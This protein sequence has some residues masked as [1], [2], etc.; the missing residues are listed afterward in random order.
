MLPVL[1]NTIWAFAFFYFL[2]FLTKSAA[3]TYGQIS[4]CNISFLG[5]KK[6]TW[7][8][9]PTKDQILVIILK[10]K[11]YTAL[12]SIFSKTAQDRDSMV[13]IKVK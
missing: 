3:Q 1:Q 2:H 9:W 10:P 8:P 5:M 11:A 4:M 7:Q 6:I 13:S 12:K